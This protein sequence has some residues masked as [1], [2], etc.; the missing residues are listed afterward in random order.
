[1]TISQFAAPVQVILLDI[2]GTTTP[3]DFV[4]QTLFPYARRRLRAYLTERGSDPQ[5][6]AELANL[7]AEHAADV[8]EQLHPPPWPDGAQALDGAV[9]YLDYLMESDR[10]S[11]PLKSL[12]GKIWAAGYQAGELQSVVFEDVPGALQRWRNQQRRIYIYSSGSVLAQRLLFAHTAAG[13]LTSL[14]DGYFDTS[15]GGK[16]EAASYGR[17]AQALQV[18]P[19]EMLFISDVS[20]ELEAAHHAGLQT[21]LSLRPG[22]PAQDQLGGGRVV[23][24]FDEVLP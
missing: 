5:V 17:I 13:D 11:T 8:R 19:A 12:Q 21:L 2:E 16:K 1:M 24:T 18:N 7:R 22:N 6:Q 14:I 10:K 20:A 15:I 3:L 9:A 23:T 4:Q